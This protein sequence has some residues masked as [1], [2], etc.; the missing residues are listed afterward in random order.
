MNV[1]PGE[2]PLFMF[3][4]AAVVS[5]CAF[6]SVVVWVTAQTGER[7]SRDRLA[8]LK[9]LAENPGENAQR[10]LAYVREDEASRRARRA[11]EERKGY[12]VGAA[13]CTAMGIA[14]WF[15]L[16][17]FVGAL[18]FAIGIAMLPFGIRWKR[19]PDEAR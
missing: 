17:P 7:K 3:L 13:L 12:L 2:T 6:V 8:L 9:A 16:V 1:I 5:G 18:L 14:F 4:A 19:Q 10:V 11:A 15:T